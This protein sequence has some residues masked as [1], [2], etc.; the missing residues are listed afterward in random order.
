MAGNGTLTLRTI[1]E[2]NGD[3]IDIEFTDTGHGIKDSDRNRLFEPFFTTKEVGKGTGLGLAISYSIV[4]KHQG[5]IRVQSQLGI[6]S[7]FV[8]RLPVKK[9]IKND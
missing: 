2:N 6:G 9:E 3:F 4:R 1:L 8:V 7:T 5:D